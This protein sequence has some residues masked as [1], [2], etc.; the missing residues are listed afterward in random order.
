MADE[1][2]LIPDAAG[3]NVGRLGRHV[4]HDPRSLAY[5]AATAPVRS[6][7]HRHYGP[8]LDQGNTSA[9]TGFA[10]SQ[11]LNTAPLHTGQPLFGETTARA[12][13][14]RATELDPFPGQYPPD[15]TGSDG[16]S[17]CKA[18]A[19]AGLIVGYD[20]A[21]GLDHLLG[22]L[23]LAPVIVGIDWHEGFDSPDIAGRV[24]L[25]GK[26]RGGHEFALTGLNVT[27][28]LVRAV[29][30]WGPTWGMHGAFWVS[31]DDL[32]SLLAAGGDCTTLR[33]A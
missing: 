21:F 22:A 1:R 14:S 6:V 8:A 31:F 17:A 24:K 4:N 33:R 16:L 20:H 29:N 26:V 18:A 15:D 11:A 27:A 5:P 28:R 7:L 2:R 10:V 13:Y 19:E 3:G 25:T 23:V 12:I 9:C 32:A 30:S